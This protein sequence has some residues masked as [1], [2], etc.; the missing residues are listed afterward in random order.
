MQ[1]IEEGENYFI[2]QLL[3]CWKN[4][5]GHGVLVNTSFNKAG[6]VIVNDIGDALET[7]KKTSI[8]YLVIGFQDSFYLIKKAVNEKA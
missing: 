4:K 3:T 1:V 2:E 6:D 5:T 8:S 7:L